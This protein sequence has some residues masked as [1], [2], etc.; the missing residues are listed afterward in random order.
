MGDGLDDA[1]MTV[2]VGRAP[3]PIGQCHP[4]PWTWTSTSTSKCS[5]IPLIQKTVRSLMAK[6]SIRGL[7]PSCE[8]EKL[9]R[10]ITCVP[11]RKERRVV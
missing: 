9:S 2:V 8:L 6:Q 3:G 10:S 7:S 5:P 1:M 4:V 11:L